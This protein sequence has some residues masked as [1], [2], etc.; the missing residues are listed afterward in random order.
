M[1]YRFWFVVSAPDIETAE[2]AAET[3]LS[4]VLPKEDGQGCCLHCVGSWGGFGGRYIGDLYRSWRDERPEGECPSM[5]P[6]EHGRPASEVADRVDIVP[7]EQIVVV[8]GNGHVCN[9]VIVRTDYVSD[10]QPD[11]D[12]WYG[13]GSVAARATVRDILTEQS[14]DESEAVCMVYVADING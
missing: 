13:N 1:H 8:D 4:H 5:S 10:S 7:P 2:M 12:T 6:E 3:A 9:M 11:C 14:A